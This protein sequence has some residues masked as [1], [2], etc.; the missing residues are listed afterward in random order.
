MIFVAG[1]ITPFAVTLPEAWFLVWKP[2]VQ[3]K[4]QMVS[5]LTQSLDSE[6][7]K[8]GSVRWL[9]TA[10]GAASLHLRGWGRNSLWQSGSEQNHK[11]ANTAEFQVRAQDLETQYILL[12]VTQS[13]IVLVTDRS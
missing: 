8:L 10:C 3:G 11:M 5:V 12:S 6:E 2:L 4:D 7:H 13:K 1:F 9:S